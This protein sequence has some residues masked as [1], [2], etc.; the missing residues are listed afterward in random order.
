MNKDGIARYL[1]REQYAQIPNG[2]MEARME[3]ERIEYARITRSLEELK[4]KGFD[5]T[6][7]FALNY[8]LELI[9]DLRETMTGLEW[10]ADDNVE[11]MDNIKAI[12]LEAQKHG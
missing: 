1:T 7:A 9:P 8:I 10:Y 2:Q 12:I 11:I 4:E 3:L 6:P 5:I